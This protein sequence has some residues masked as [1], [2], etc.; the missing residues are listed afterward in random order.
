MDM[1]SAL[2]EIRTVDID[3]P[4]RYREWE[5]PDGPTFVCVHGLGGTH[6]NWMAVAPGLS[7]HGRVLAMDL[8]GF[9]LTPRAGRSAGLPANR[10]LIARFIRELATPP[11]I[12]VG[13]SMGGGLAS[14]QAALDPE[15][16]AG[17]VLTGPAIPW[18]RAIKPERLVVAGFT[19]YR[20]PAVS[21]WVIRNRTQRIGPERLVDEALK[22]CCVDPSRVPQDM[23]KA[24]VDLTRERE[25]DRD[26]IPA[27]LEA[28]RSLMRVKDHPEFVRGIVDR[29]RSPV[30]LIHG[31]R[32]R[33]VPIELARETARGRTNW[34]LEELDDVGHV[35]MMEA[36][37]RW[38]AAVESWLPSLGLAAPE[39]AASAPSA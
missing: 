19:F 22:I 25:R 12:L 6:L 3:G 27:F 14:V 23:V 5:G 26:S 9:G 32:D 31:T 7:R 35:T 34:R 21:D 8:A 13:N 39:G 30:L 36:P 29:V 16:V 20:I 18:T 28:A 1:S 15:S 24:Q 17:L 33:L 11:V 10:R 4:V 2:P 38:L 37:D